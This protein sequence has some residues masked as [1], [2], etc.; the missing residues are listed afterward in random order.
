S[1]A[2]EAGEV[3]A[4]KRDVEERLVKLIEDVKPAVELV[5]PHLFPLLERLKAG[6]YS[7]LPALEAELPKLA[8]QHRQLQKLV[9]ELG[10]ARKSLEKVAHIG[11]KVKE[12]EKTLKKAPEDVKAAFGEALKALERMDFEGAVRE[13]NK[14]L[15]IVEEKKAR[16]QPLEERIREATAVAEQLGLAKVAKALER[17]T[18]KNV[19]KA[20]GELER[21]LARVYG[22][23]ELAEY[24]KQPRADADFGHA[25]AVARVLGLEEADRLF[26]ALSEASLFLLREGREIF[27][28]PLYDEVKYLVDQE[29]VRS[30]VKAPMYSYIIDRLGHDILQPTYAKWYDLFVE[31]GPYLNTAFEHARTSATK[32]RA[33]LGLTGGFSYG[34][35]MMKW[36][37]DF[38]QEAVVRGLKAYYSGEGRP[39]RELSE[40]T[41]RGAEIQ[42]FDKAASLLMAKAAQ[43]LSEA[44]SEEAA[45]R[46]VA[47]AN[48]LKLLA[49]ALRAKA[50]YEE[51]RLVQTYLKGAQRRAEALLREAELERD[52]DRKLALE[53]KAREM[54]EAAQRKAE[55]H[56]ADARARYKAYLAEVRDFVG[57]HGDVREVGMKY[58]GLTARAFA[59]D[60]Q[61]VAEKMIR[62]VDVRRVISWADELKLPKE[63]GEIAVRIVDAERV[64]N[65]FEKILRAKVEPIPPVYD[66]EKAGRFFAEEARPHPPPPKSRV[67][68]AVPKVVK[69]VLTAYYGRL[70]NAAEKAAVYLALIKN[71][72]RHA[73]QEVKKAYRVLQK[74]LKAGSREEALKAL[75]ELKAALKALGI[76]AEGE[77]V[78]TVLKAV[79]ERM[80]PAY[81]EYVNARR[82]YVSAVEAVAKFSPEAA[83]ALG[84]AARE[85]GL[86]SIGRWMALVAYETAK[87]ALNEYAWFWARPVEERWDSLPQAVRELI[88]RR[89]EEAV[90]ELV[91]NTLKSAGIGVKKGVEMDLKTYEEA[92]EKVFTA[93]GEWPE[94]RAYVKQV[95]EAARRVQRGKASTEE[96]EKAVDELFR[97]YGAKAAERFVRSDR[98]EDAVE[99]MHE[100]MRH[101]ARNSGLKIGRE[102]AERALFFGLSAMPEDVVEAYAKGGWRGRLEPYVAYWTENEK[103]ARRAGEAGWEVRQIQRPVS[104]EE[105]VPKEWRT[106][107]VVAS[108]GFDLSAVERSVVEYVDGALE[109]VAR[110]RPV[111]W[112]VPEVFLWF[113]LKDRQ[114]AREGGWITA[115][116]IDK[117][118]IEEPLSKFGEALKAKNYDEMRKTVRELY[119]ARLNRTLWQIVYE[120]DRERAE[121]AL[122]HLRQRYGVSEGRLWERHDELYLT[123][124]AFRLADESE[125]YLR[126]GA[127]R[128]LRTKEEVA[129][130]ASMPWL[131]VELA[132]LFWLRL[133]GDAEGGPEFRNTWVTAVNMWFERM[134]EPYSPKKPAVAK[135]AVELFNAFVGAGFKY[136]E[137]FPPPQKPEAQKPPS[138]RLLS[139]KPSSRLRG[140]LW[141]LLKN[142]V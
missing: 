15:K 25:W 47:E 103:L 72:T 75:E 46:L 27:H 95:I 134:A 119:E 125:A 104:F 70:K 62:A 53:A 92:L 64:Y 136:E 58:F 99:E 68:E 52:V 121:A 108:F 40:L 1:L 128:G 35:K 7:V 91:R 76:E 140:R 2:R 34:G 6:D 33:P 84:E 50:A 114:P 82:E 45:K 79:E 83:L 22:A 139:L 60:P 49:F 123:W 87:R 56:L 69:D 120:F 85:G 77:D 78:K 24:I 109:G 55:K 101:Y 8:E 54:Q 44:S 63:L 65:K 80:R 115:Y 141:R 133:V 18:E 96:L 16:L 3:I 61:E 66:L 137:L 43:M 129:G 126:S 5:A 88:A 113:I 100:G 30:L 81:E 26:R 118:S 132:P 105:G 12:L 110:V 51:V 127:G 39:F 97:A 131:P 32:A 37:G 116:S 122:E 21:E 111:E 19:S 20:L 38:S 14:I 142:V 10:E 4:A 124:L 112:P 28:N 71:D 9:D 86:D 67:E 74:A 106:A 107:Y 41:V 59:G 11:K 135:K 23:L 102:A 138:R 36:L 89:E 31:Y 13:L 98:L 130:A 94:L 73:S 90:Y 93:N 48:E 42:L 29:H 17:P 117:L 57:S